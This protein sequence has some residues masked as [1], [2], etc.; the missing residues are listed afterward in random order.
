MSNVILHLT[1]DK[2]CTMSYRSKIGR[3]VHYGKSF[4]FFL[5][6]DRKKCRD[7]LFIRKVSREFFSRLE[8]FTSGGNFPQS[9]EGKKR[10]QK[11]FDSIVPSYLLIVAEQT[12]K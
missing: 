10:K 6:F 11:V 5:G 3:K 7:F 2:V 9:S 1:Y 4:P 12:Q 8:L